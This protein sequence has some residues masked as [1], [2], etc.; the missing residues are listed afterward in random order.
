V[1]PVDSDLDMTYG[2]LH[3][4]SVRVREEPPV[5]DFELAI[6]ELTA[7]YRGRISRDS[8]VSALKRQGE[9]VAADDG[10]NME[11]ATPAEDAPQPA[12]DPAA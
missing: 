11:A 7:M 5:K 2:E 10:W 8:A 12:D 3:R 6:S 1:T 4:T 9:E